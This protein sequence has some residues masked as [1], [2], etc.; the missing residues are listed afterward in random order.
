MKNIK[1]QKNWLCLYL[2][3][4]LFL[5][6]VVGVPIRA[7]NGRE[8]QSEANP[9]TGDEFD[10]AE[11]FKELLQEARGAEFSAAACFRRKR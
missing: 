9:Q 7:Q 6:S 5:N 3:A 4:A 8:F 11:N 1:S 2:T 10:R